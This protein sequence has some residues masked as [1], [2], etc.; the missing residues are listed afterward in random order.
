MGLSIADRTVRM[1]LTHIK[2]KLHTDDLVN[3]VVI[4][5]RSGM[6]DQEWRELRWRPRRG[7]ARPE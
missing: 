3:A 2:R 5:V 7:A 6:I 1:H 4:A